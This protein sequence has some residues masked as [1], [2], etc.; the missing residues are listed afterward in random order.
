MPGMFA[1]Q[2]VP[3]APMTLT[4]RPIIVSGETTI[5]VDVWGSDIAVKRDGSNRVVIASDVE[6]Y[7]I[8]V[9]A[10]DNTVRVVH[11]HSWNFF[12]VLTEKLGWMRSG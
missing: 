2:I 1:M 5:R 9:Y 4:S 11:A 10:T 7:T 12:D 8:N 3:V 6:P